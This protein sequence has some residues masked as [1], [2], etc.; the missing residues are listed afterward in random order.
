[1]ELTRVILTGERKYLNR[2]IKKWWEVG[3]K[4]EPPI[5]DEGMDVFLVIPEDTVS[6]LV[7]IADNLN[8]ETY[9]LN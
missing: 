1:M 3:E 6:G 8:L 7:A 9:I 4:G 2:F 5:I